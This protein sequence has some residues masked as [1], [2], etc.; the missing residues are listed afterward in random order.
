MGAMAIIDRISAKY[1]IGM[2][3]VVKQQETED[4]YPGNRI[5]LLPLPF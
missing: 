3:V 2:S 4:H 5:L 1:R